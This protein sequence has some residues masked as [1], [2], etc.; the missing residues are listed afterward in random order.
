MDGFTLDAFFK[1]LPIKFHG[2]TSIASIAKKRDRGDRGPFDN[3][4][5]VYENRMIG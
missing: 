3:G 4:L 1:C 2:T 5:V